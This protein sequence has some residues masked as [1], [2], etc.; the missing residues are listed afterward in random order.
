M[1]L[2][3]IIPAYCEESKIAADVSAA[4]TYLAEHGFAGEVIVVDDGSSDRTAE[5]AAAAPAPAGIRRRLIRFDR[6]RGKGAA[7]RA[8]IAASS[9]RFLLFADAGLCIPYANAD[10]ALAWLQAGRCDLAVG[11]RF[12]P[13]S[14]IVRPH[15]HWRRLLSRGFRRAV[16]RLAGLRT[17]LS[18]TQCGF[19]LFQGDLGRELFAACKT[20]GF[21]FDLEILLRAE[22]R[23]ARIRQFPVEWRSDPDSRFPPLLGPAQCLLD[24]FRIKHR[25]RNEFRGRSRRPE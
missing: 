20:D 22:Q 12:L 2:S 11:A 17:P 21:L 9:G 7:V 4:G 13:E 10:P 5:A 15:S 23:G 1:E 18:D 3:I 8:G 16:V 6:N 14:R 24:L 19:K 25:L